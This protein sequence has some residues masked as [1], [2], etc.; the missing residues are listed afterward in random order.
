[1]S[2]VR[3][4]KSLLDDVADYKELGADFTISVYTSNAERSYIEAPVLDVYT[5]GLAVEGT[6]GVR[7]LLPLSNIA[8]IDIYENS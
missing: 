4:Q 2:V 1:M 8:A 6:D 7:V 3:K 5:D